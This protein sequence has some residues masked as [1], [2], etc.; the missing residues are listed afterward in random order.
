[1][2]RQ[3]GPGCKEEAAARI[4]WRS[5]GGGGGGQEEAAARTRQREGPGGE[6]AA[7]ARRRQR[8]PAAVP[9][10]PSDGFWKLVASPSFSWT[11]PKPIPILASGSVGP[12]DS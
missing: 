4:R 12:A 3:G 8:S 7:E 2:R 10:A 5:G 1:M 11:R 6:E 9:S